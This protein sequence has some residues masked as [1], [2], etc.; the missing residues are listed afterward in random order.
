MSGVIRNSRTHQAAADD[1]FEEL[2]DR[3]TVKWRGISKTWDKKRHFSMRL[4][5]STVICN[6][7]H[8]FD[9][10]AEKGK[11]RPSGHWW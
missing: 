5:L 4:T 7:S 1:K 10:G 9:N 3:V 11:G 8:T 6:I 2:E